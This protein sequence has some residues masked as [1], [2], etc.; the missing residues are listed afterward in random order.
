MK[1][2]SKNWEKIIFFRFP[3]PPPPLFARLVMAAS[4]LN[5]F[6]GIGTN[7]RELNWRQS[8]LGFHHINRSMQLWTQNDLLFYFYLFTFWETV[9]QNLKMKN[10]SSKWTVIVVECR[11][12]WGTWIGSFWVWGWRVHR[13]VFFFF[14]NFSSNRLKW[15]LWLWNII[16]QVPST[17]ICFKSSLIL[18]KE[19]KTLKKPPPKNSLQKFFDLEEKKNDF[20]S[21][22]FFGNIFFTSSPSHF[23]CKWRSRK[24][25]FLEKK[26][27]NGFVL[28]TGGPIEPQRK[29]LGRS[30][31]LMVSWC[32]TWIHYILRWIPLY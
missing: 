14:F 31:L 6:N 15:K 1:S 3:P 2:K 16:L 32:L 18:E 22:S 13:S 28:P 25:V 26:W 11:L 23:L 20:F 12:V 27:K 17:K 19:K 10:W 5:F 24:K 30:R 9:K 7:G 4:G 21:F 29:N 8:Q